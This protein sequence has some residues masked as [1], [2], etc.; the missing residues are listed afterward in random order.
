MARDWVI[1]EINLELCNLCGVCV[2]YCP[3][4]AVE[5]G[6][7]GPFIARPDDCSYCAQCSE[8]CPQEAI[9]C[10]YEIVWSNDVCAEGE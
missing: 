7:D 2:D 10:W 3:T 5:M 1:P 4:N 8:I 6:P 9:V